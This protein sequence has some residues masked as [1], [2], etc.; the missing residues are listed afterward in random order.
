MNEAAVQAEDAAMAARKESVDT[1]ITS[2]DSSLEQLP[3][4]MKKQNI[5]ASAQPTTAS[6]TAAE[7]Q[8]APDNSEAT[9]EQ[10]SA[11]TEM[12]PSAV[13]V[14]EEETQPVEDLQE[15]PNE[16]PSPQ[17]QGEKQESTLDLVFE[18][19]LQRARERAREKS[20]S[21]PENQPPD[22]FRQSGSHGTQVG[23]EIG[24]ECGQVQE[25][26]PG[27]DA[28]DEDGLGLYPK[29]KTTVQ[30]DCVHVREYA[31]TIGDSPFCSSGAPVSL[32]WD[33]SENEAVDI[34]VFEYHHK[35][36][37]NSRK[38]MMLSPVQ[39]RLLLWRSGHNLED[40]D[41]AAK[42]N[43]KE[44]F[45]QNLNL[46][47]LPVQLVQEFFSTQSDRWLKKSHRGIEYLEAQVRQLHRN[48]MQKAD[49]EH[50]GL[51]PWQQEAREIEDRR[52][53]P[54][55]RISLRKSGSSNALPRS[56]SYSSLQSEASDNDHSYYDRAVSD[57]DMSTC[58]TASRFV[59]Y[60]IQTDP[61]QHDKA[62]E[63][64]LC[65]IER[66]HMRAFHAS[67][68]G[69]FIGFIMWFAITPLLGE[70]KETLGL[71]NAEIWTSSLAGTT[72]TV[73]ARVM[74]G[75][76]CDMFG[77]R[78]CMAAIVILSAIPCGLTGLVN[79]A[80]G[81]SAVRAFIGIGGSAF[82]PCQYWTSRMFAREVVGTANAL[83]AGWGNLGGGVTQLMMGSGLFPLFEVIYQGFDNPEELAW[84]TVFVIPALIAFMAAYVYIY[85]CDDSP[86]GDFAELVRQQQIEVV[87]P[88]WSLGIAIQNR[89]VII[90]IFQYACCF[91]VEIT[92]TN[93][94]ALYM[95]EEFGLDTASA[96][97]VAS[98]FGIMNLFARGLGGYGSDFLNARYGTKGRVV[99]QGFT[100]FL[101]GCGI[102]LF[103]YMDTLPTAILSLIFLSLWVQAS[104]GATYGIVPYVNRR[105]TGA[106]VGWVG[107]GGTL[108]GV[109]FSLLFREFDYEK[110]FL[111]MGISAC[112]SALLS[113]FM[114]MKSLA[115]IYREKMRTETIKNSNAVFHDDLPVVKRR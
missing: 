110:A 23:L 60:N 80:A 89:N 90:L 16:V 6:T 93:A 74:M 107:A 69:F 53:G 59:T 43:E 103:A 92:M 3:E 82:V 12:T 54:E 65:S 42:E 106:V 67:W 83:V 86:K 102:I 94:T 61:R 4:A 84:R 50:G 75:P 22:D 25:V 8:Y 99:W 98:I 58:S 57:D 38:R 96:A 46:F 56:S 35:R 72:V 36:A 32:D 11:P 71:T 34:D 100:L 10:S 66:P 19:A 115:A 78:K 91:G 15:Q 39:R 55:R 104:E 5:D 101:E 79:T 109:G 105:F 27:V 14:S 81:L 51:P 1:S 70:V 29:R 37:R 62:T 13:S 2:Y 41:K 9:E 63:I 111:F 18:R 68:F 7:D 52:K 24:Y 49:T 108:G 113:I 45:R 40:I 97:A 33:Y 47:F 87:S 17:P 30:F 20:T 85:K 44:H 76:M 48:Q 21:A 28:D 31:I 112:G 64:I 26:F 73:L 77:A 88:F 114:N 95:K